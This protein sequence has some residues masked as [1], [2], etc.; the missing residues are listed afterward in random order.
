MKRISL[1]DDLWEMRDRL[2]ID[3]ERAIDPHMDKIQRVIMSLD[4][5][6]LEMKYTF[7]VDFHELEQ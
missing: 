2:H 4:A 3:C 5:L 6:L 1:S 7:Q